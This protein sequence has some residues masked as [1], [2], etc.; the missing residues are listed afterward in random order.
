MVRFDSDVGGFS[1]LNDTAAELLRLAGHS[2]SVP[3]AYALQDLPGALERVRAALA[4][5]QVGDDVSAPDDDD[6]AEPPV[7]LSARVFPFVKL[8][9]D[10]IAN[11]S[12]VRWRSSAS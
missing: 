3:G 10:A 4:A 6:D 1:T 11:S 9:E 12:G 8:L 5:Q 7:Q 2:G